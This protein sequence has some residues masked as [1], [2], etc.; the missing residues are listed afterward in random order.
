MLGQQ[1]LEVRM[2][3]LRHLVLLVLLFSP[4]A[5]ADPIFPGWFFGNT[6]GTMTFD[7]TAKTLSLTSTITTIINVNQTITGSNLGTITVT[8]GPLTSGTI[9]HSALFAGGTINI[10]LNFGFT[11]DGTL[12][13][14]LTWWMDT[15]GGFHLGGGGSAVGDGRDRTPITNFR[16]AVVL[17]GTNQY[18]VL[19]GAT[20]LPEPGT[21]MLFGTGLGLLGAAT[22]LRR[23]RIQ[24]K[25]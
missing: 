19:K 3:P 2:R 7:P 6:G 14:P 12:S 17:S 22:L 18:S 24:A 20:V 4:A 11:L 25:S 1:N 21:V 5:F 13:V 8:T 16:Q 9:F 23:F 15:S 10:T